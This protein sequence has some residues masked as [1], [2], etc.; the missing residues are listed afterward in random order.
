M[1]GKHLVKEVTARGPEIS[2]RMLSPK[3]RETAHKYFD[4]AG[5]NLYASHGV[6]GEA[7]KTMVENFISRA[8]ER[9]QKELDALYGSMSESEKAALDKHREILDDY[10]GVYVDGFVREEAFKLELR[11]EQSPDAISG[12][13]LPY[14]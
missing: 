12:I 13:N 5:T 8:T 1:D 6:D 9:V 4:W 7:L 11:D 14:K 2:L 3:E 10:I